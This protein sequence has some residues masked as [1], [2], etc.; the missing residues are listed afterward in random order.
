MR[1]RGSRGVRWCVQLEQEA[2][3]HHAAV[4]HGGNAAAARADLDQRLDDVISFSRASVWRE[5]AR[6]E[7]G[8]AAVTVAPGK[9]AAPAWLETRVGR[10]TVLAFALIGFVAT[11]HLDIMARRNQQNCLAMLVLLSILWCTE[12]IP[13]Y[14]TSMLVPA[15]TVLLRVLP[16]DHHKH[17]DMPAPEAAQRVFSVRCACCPP[18]LSVNSAR[19]QLSIAVLA[20]VSRSSYTQLVAKQPRT[21]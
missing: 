16:D 8:R 5:H 2:L 3:A 1:A 17:K 13:L 18:V 19:C 12:V 6:Y 20:H 7:R 4:K 9:A 10:A 21:L 15:L 14:V 11:M